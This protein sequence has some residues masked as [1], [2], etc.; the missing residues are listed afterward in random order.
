MSVCRELKKERE[1]ERLLLFN[2]PFA[3][4]VEYLL[5]DVC[6]LTRFKLSMELTKAN[7]KRE[8]KN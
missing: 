5:I 8:L 1:R 7:E 3:I 2:P 6:K 4:A